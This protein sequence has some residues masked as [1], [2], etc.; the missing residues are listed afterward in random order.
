[1]ELLDH[2][3]VCLAPLPGSMSLALTHDAMT[4]GH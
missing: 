2:Q 4:L 1:M 3:N